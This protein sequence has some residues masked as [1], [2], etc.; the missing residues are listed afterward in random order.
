[1]VSCSPS[2]SLTASESNTTPTKEETPVDSRLSE[3]QG[4]G[5][6]GLLAMLPPVRSSAEAAQLGDTALRAGK[7][8]EA[9]LTSFALLSST[10]KTMSAY[11]RLV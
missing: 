10:R 2:I 1:M 5:R 8:E 3:L 11:T 7:R 6:S 9:L 4:G